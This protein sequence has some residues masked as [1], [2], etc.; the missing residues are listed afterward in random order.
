MFDQDWGYEGAANNNNAVEFHSEAI[1]P[2]SQNNFILKIRIEEELKKLQHLSNHRIDSLKTVR[3]LKISGDYDDYSAHSLC[4]YLS[5]KELF[6]YPICETAVVVIGR[7]LPSI[8]TIQ[9]YCNIDVLLCETETNVS[10]NEEQEDY[11]SDN[12]YLK[13]ALF[14]S[15]YIWMQTKG[16]FSF[17]INDRLNGVLGNKSTTSSDANYV[18]VISL[19]TI[20]I[21]N[22]GE[23]HL[24]FETFS[25]KTVVEQPSLVKRCDLKM[26]SIDRSF[27]NIVTGESVR[28]EETNVT[29]VLSRHDLINRK[30]GYSTHLP[31]TQEQFIRYWQMCFGWDLKAEMC[32]G[33]K[34][35]LV[36]VSTDSGAKILPESVLARSVVEIPARTRRLAKDIKDKIL[37]LLR[38]CPFL[39][40]VEE[41]ERVTVRGPQRQQDGDRPMNL[42]ARLGTALSL[43]KKM[44]QAG[45]VPVGSG[46]GITDIKATGGSSG[47]GSRGA[48]LAVQRA[49]TTPGAAVTALSRKPV[50]RGPAVAIPALHS[51]VQ[52]QR[53]EEDSEHSFSLASS[54]GSVQ[55]P[56]PP[57]ILT[58]PV[59]LDTSSSMQARRPP[60]QDEEE[61]SDDSFSLGESSA[62]EEEEKEKEDDE[63][64]ILFAATNTVGMKGIASTSTGCSA[65][66]SRSLF[67]KRKETPSQ[68]KVISSSA[69]K[70]KK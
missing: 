7:D 40:S 43:K 4:V 68:D 45:R 17:K 5:T 31:E 14:Y 3:I 25:Y 57:P 41:E 35:R 13:H 38:T 15:I 6:A 42:S 2:I 16:W 30:K 70:K 66:T 32:N 10:M 58:K 60:S 49:S 69:C 64:S 28:L 39:S 44:T 50:A 55:P 48:D 24:S 12:Q 29:S 11:V 47:S 20:T 8:R 21:G 19:N 52:Q 46:S 18:D 34:L 51:D 26:D 1:A 33:S 61:R 65:S 23:T 62:G 22:D 63:D 56:S 53:Q 37:N 27:V 59:V 67:T 54:Q 9:E 36:E